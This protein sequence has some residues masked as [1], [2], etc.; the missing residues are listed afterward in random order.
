MQ[1]TDEKETELSS[2]GM[3]KKKTQGFGK[4]EATRKKIIT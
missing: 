2:K 3:Q 4:E 1:R